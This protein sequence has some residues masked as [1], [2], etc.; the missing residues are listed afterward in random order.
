VCVFQA[1]LLPYRSGV[2]QITARF[3][4]AVIFAIVGRLLLL[5]TS[6]RLSRF[7]VN[8][9]IWDQPSAIGITISLVVAVVAAMSLRLDFSW[10]DQG[11]VAEAPEWMECYA[12]FGLI[13]TLI[14]LY[15]EMLRVLAI[16]RLT[17]R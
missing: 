1:V 9:T 14:W 10:I 12:A 3:I 15:A 8:L 13:S 16:S 2:V 7:D 11:V 4:K 17:R 5:L 6:W